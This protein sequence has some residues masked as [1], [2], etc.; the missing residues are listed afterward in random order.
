MSVTGEFACELSA[1]AADITDLTAA[2]LPV[3][4]T[5]TWETGT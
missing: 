4:G 1:P 2:Q 5:I 3:L